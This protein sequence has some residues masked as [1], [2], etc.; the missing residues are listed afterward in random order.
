V[1]RV[2]YDWVLEDVTV[3]TTKTVTL[4]YPFTGHRVTLSPTTCASTART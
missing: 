3:A 2:D 1:T 4:S